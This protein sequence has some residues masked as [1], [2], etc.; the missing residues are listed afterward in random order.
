MQHDA[1]RARIFELMMRRSSFLGLL[2]GTAA[3]QVLGAQPVLAQTPRR[4]GVLKVSAPANP[5]SLDPYTGGSGLDHSF[6]YTIFD[7][8]IEWEYETL[9]ARPGLAEAGV[10]PIRRRWC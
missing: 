2:G 5:S 8:L 1:R 3:A 7:T 10:S 4:G 6:L 9:K